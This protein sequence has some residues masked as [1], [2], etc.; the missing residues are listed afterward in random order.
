LLSDPQKSPLA[1]LDLDQPPFPIADVETTRTYSPFVL[2]ADE[3]VQMKQFP[4]PKLPQKISTANRMIAL[5]IFYVR[6]D[7]PVVLFADESEA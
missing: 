6:S 4:F 2:F 7:R 1:A 3:T 5:P